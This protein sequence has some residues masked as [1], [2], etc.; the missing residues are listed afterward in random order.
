MIANDDPRRLFVAGGSDAHGDFNYASHLSFNNYADD[1]A[2]GKAQTVAFVPGPWSATNLPPMND[3]LAA[4]RAGHTI[5][6]DGPFVEIGIDT[7]GDADWYG[8]QDMIVG[9]AGSLNPGTPALLHLRWNSLPEFGSI[10]SVRLL[11]VSGAGSTVLAT[12]NFP[13]GMSGAETFALG[14]QGFLGRVSFRAELRTDDGLAGYRAYTNP[15]EVNFDP[16]T[17]SPPIAAGTRTYNTPN[18][19]NP[20]TEIHFTVAQDGPVTLD[21]YSSAGRLVRRLIAPRTMPQ[22]HHSIEWDGRD[23]R[24][25][26]LASGIYLYSVRTDQGVQSGKMSLIR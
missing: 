18:P 12:Y 6:T 16:A 24:G 17:S 11:A 14:G 8:T 1:N 3:I 4:Y 15:I 25:G 9:D 21:I 26:D 7:D 20:R 19:F 2:I 22:G 13:S 23:D 5:I 10:A